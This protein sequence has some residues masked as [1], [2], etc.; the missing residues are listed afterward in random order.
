M[1]GCPRSRWRL[2]DL[3]G[4][5]PAL[6]GYS[7]AGVC[8]A[9]RRLGVRRKRGR[10]GIHSPDLAY[11]AKCT[12]IGGALASARRCPQAVSLLFGDEFSLY[13]QPTLGSV[14]W[15]E[16]EE[17][18][19][20]L[21]LRS[22]TRW[23]FSGA[24]DA[25]SGR[26]VWSGRAKMGVEG[27]RSFLER[28]RTAYPGRRLLLVWD[29]WPVHQH[30]QVLR[31]AAELGIELLWVPTYAPWTNNVE[32]LWR[33]LKEE[34]HRYHRLADLWEELKARVADF[35]NR[36]SEGSTELLAYVGLLPD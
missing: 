34:L 26:V 5:V 31:R 24:L 12:L 11:Q 22:N 1:Y 28:L 30:P 3:V 16:G 13:R 17:P 10:L 8:K 29:N 14:Y 18:V 2:C 35:L 33:W 6:A 4:A 21:S 27:L 7:L 15:P 36:F 9:L 32:K 20:H 19:A 23:R 25:V